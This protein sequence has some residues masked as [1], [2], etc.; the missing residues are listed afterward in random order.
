MGEPENPEVKKGA[1]LDRE[2]LTLDSLMAAC[3]P[4]YPKGPYAIAD[5]AGLSAGD[6]SEVLF[7]AARIRGLSINVRT[8]LEAREG[9]LFFGARTRAIEVTCSRDPARLRAYLLLGKKDG[10][11]LVRLFR[12][13]E[14]PT[15]CAGRCG[16]GNAELEA[17]V[18]HACAQAHLLAT[19]V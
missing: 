17:Y 16:I 10:D 12:I 11:V 19:G 1:V 15:G 18:R 4:G 3:A 6:W 9:G 14:E 8:G 7:R 5:G 2:D 13:A